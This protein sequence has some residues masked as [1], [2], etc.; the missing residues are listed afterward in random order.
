MVFDIPRKSLQAVRFSCCWV[1]SLWSGWVSD[2]AAQELDRYL[3]EKAEMGVPFRI[4]LYARGSREARTAADAAFERVELLNGVCSDYDPDSE[5]SRLCH[6]P[7]PGAAIPVSTELW[8]V[9]VLSQELAERSRGAFDIT[10]GPLVNLWRR[11]RRRGELPDQGI[12]SEALLRVGYKKLRLDPAAQAVSF[13]EGEMRLDLG[14]IAKGVAVDAALEVLSAR[15]IRSAL[16]AAS[17]DIGASGA[18]PGKPGWKVEVMA[19]DVPGA[20]PPKFVWLKN[21]AVSTAGDTFQ[22][23]EID[24][25]RYSHIVDPRTGMGVTDHSLSTVLGPNCTTTDGLETTL[26]VLGPERGLELVRETPGTAA[27]IVRQPRDRLEV[28]ESPSW[29]ELSALSGP[30]E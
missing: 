27:Y 3:F 26:S 2:V 5:L 29:S 11:A 30:R 20:P 22:R 24:G 1:A 28:Y 23:V 21:S 10:V 19:L 6:R 18:P 16:V 14:G 9:L 7:W 8:R 25:V 17:G 12:L 4:T 13:T 15:G